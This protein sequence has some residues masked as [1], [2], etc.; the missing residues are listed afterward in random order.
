MKVMIMA[1]GTGGH[2]FPALAVAAQLQNRNHQ[3]C[4]L[5]SKGGME[6][7]L[8]S[9]HEIPL[10]TIP[11]A[12]LR[13][14]G[15]AG[16]LMAPFRLLR[17]L[18]LAAKVIKQEAPSVVL[19]MGGFVAGPGGVASWLMGI[20]LVIHEQNGVAGLTNRLLRRIATTTLQGF[21]GAFG[22]NTCFEV[23]GNPVRAEITTLWQQPST[24]FDGSRPL[25]LLVLG[26]SR[27]AAALNRLIPELLAA[28]SDI[29]V[30]HQSGQVDYQQTLDE[31]QAKN[32]KAD[33]SPFIENMSD[34]YQ[35]ADLVI[36]R[37]GALTVSE[38]A[39]AG[40]GAILV[41]YPYA[42]DDHQTINAQWLQ[43]EGAGVVIQQAD[44]TL[45]R[46]LSEVEKLSLPETINAMSQAA[47]RV[48][49]P[50]SAKQVTERLLEAAA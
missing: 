41:P 7:T 1:G 44:L 31:Y 15:A 19:G 48:A 12:G 6:E 33:V 16:W 47:R 4:W 37:A 21:P 14:N 8:V 49:Q 42:V 45:E 18:W 26:G 2:I 11:L 29:D 36:C 10:T 27:G 38:L 20:P 22:A 17:A 9:Q 23:V 24:P 40:V 13:G 46:L 25:R 43:Q 32:V 39:L 28:R 5:G 3:V 50:T 35:W 34:V 30:R